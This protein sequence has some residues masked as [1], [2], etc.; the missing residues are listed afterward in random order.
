M[1]SLVCSILELVVL[2]AVAISA[3]CA[4]NKIV[5]TDSRVTAPGPFERLAVFVSLPR[6][7][8]R[9]IYHGVKKTLPSEL[10]AC[11]VTSSIVAGVP[12]ARDAQAQASSPDAD[13]Q[14]IIRWS[15]GLLSTVTTVDQYGNVLD[16]KA[17]KKL[18]MGFWFELFDFKLNRVTWL[19]V[20]KLEMEGSGPTVGADL[21]RAIVARL[22][23]D[24]VL[25]GCR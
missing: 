22:R 1:R 4:S 5:I 2:V 18:E 3:G 7:G 17:F 15:S 6:D 25:E 20:A 10:T 9:G 8:D 21:A 13:A 11:A 24:G 19:A 14:L 12:V 23:H 16:D